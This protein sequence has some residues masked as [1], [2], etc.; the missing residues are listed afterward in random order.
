MLFELGVLFGMGKVEKLIWLVYVFFCMRFLMKIVREGMRIDGFE[1]WF[2][3]EM[4]GY[5]ELYIV[6]F[7]EKSGR[8]FGGDFLLVNSLFNFIIE[9]LK[10]GDIRLKFLVDY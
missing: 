9:V 8:M 7:Y 1:G 3:L 6:F 10:V 2:V 5:V 4:S